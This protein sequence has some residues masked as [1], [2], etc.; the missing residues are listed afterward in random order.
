MPYKCPFCCL[1]PLSHSLTKLA[2]INDT[3]YFYTCPSQAILY[4]DADSIIKHY[5][6]V[7]SEIPNDK[8]W[9]WIFDS[10]Q[11]NFKHFMQFKVG[12]ELAKLISN[13]YSEN[14]QKIVII[15]ST[16][17]VSSIYK[18]ITPFLNEKVK[19]IIDFNNIYKTSYDVLS[20]LSN[21]EK[22]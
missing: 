2:E 20:N 7:F 11:F 21:T 5:D 9:V 4:F 18:I 6:G 13:K 16:I 22:Q 17:Y 8:N 3:I 12:I 10:F 1:N 19:R 14:L 15:N